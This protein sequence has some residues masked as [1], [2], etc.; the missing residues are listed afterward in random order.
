M[1]TSYTWHVKNI[2]I[3]I[4]IIIPLLTLC[5]RWHAL[6]EKTSFTEEAIRS[7]T[8]DFSGLSRNVSHALRGGLSKHSVNV[9]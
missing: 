6:E 3:I 5:L 4:I 9:Y 1:W 8:N 7:F 2:I